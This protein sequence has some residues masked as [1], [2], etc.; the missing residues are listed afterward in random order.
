MD[1]PVLATALNALKRKITQ[2][3]RRLNSSPTGIQD[4]SIESVKLKAPSALGVVTKGASTL[5]SVAYNTKGQITSV[6]ERPY[7]A[8][9]LEGQTLNQSRILVGNSSNASVAVLMSGDVTGVYSLG[10]YVTTIG[11]GAVNLSKLSSTIFNGAPTKSPA[12]GDKIVIAD[13]TSGLTRV[14]TVGSLPQSSNVSASAQF[15]ADLGYSSEVGVFLYDSGEHEGQ[16]GWTGNAF[17]DG[18]VVWFNKT[19]GGLTAWRPYYVYQVDENYI[20]LFTNLADALVGSGDQVYPNTTA[21]YTGTGYFWSGPTGLIGE[22]VQGVILCDDLLAEESGPETGYYLVHLVDAL[23]S[24]NHPVVC[25]AQSVSAPM[26][27]CFATG[28]VISTTTIM[29]ATQDVYGSPNSP[30]QVSMVCL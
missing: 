15:F 25:N 13:G 26:L 28:R 12:A 3:E 4:D 27:A 9:G 16:L 21:A 17:T 18:D 30:Q 20:K 29:V 1:F 2:I 6:V 22:N 8:I 24:V 19:E 14:V 10:S 5:I 23:G 7:E 11:A